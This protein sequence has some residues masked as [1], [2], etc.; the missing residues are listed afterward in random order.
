MRYTLPA[1]SGQRGKSG[2]VAIAARML[3]L[4]TAALL[5]HPAAL[6]ADYPARPLQLVIP[7][8]AGGPAD[9]VG[10]LYGQHLATVL[11]QPVT[12]INRDGAAGTIGTVSGTTA[13]EAATRATSAKREA[14]RATSAAFCA[15]AARSC[16][17]VA[18]A[19]TG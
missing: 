13:A 16:A 8:P 19:G 3:M 7:F 6:A 14:S 10:R 12:I 15:S 5:N 17:R 2:V 1:N 9:I 11:G 18:P 4:L